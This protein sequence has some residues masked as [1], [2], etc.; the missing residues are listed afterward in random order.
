MRHWHWDFLLFCI[1]P[2]QHLEIGRAGEAT[3]VTTKL[4]V[5]HQ[6]ERTVSEIERKIRSL[7]MFMS[8]CRVRVGEK[9]ET[10]LVSKFLP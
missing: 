2:S 7:R 3:V 8:A 6:I 4:L 5:M 9:E 10:G 1:F